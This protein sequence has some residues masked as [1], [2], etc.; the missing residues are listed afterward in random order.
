LEG[1]TEET[2]EKNK[3]NSVS[4]WRCGKNNHF[5]TECFAK[6]NE[7]GESLVDNKINDEKK[8]KVLKKNKGDA[9]K[10]KS[11]GIK[12]EQE[13]EKEKRI[14]ELDSDSAQDF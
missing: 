12:T 3:L 6:W 8:R 11:A 7:A 4:C 9:K 14:W 2:I 5:A 13:K 10:L 1:I